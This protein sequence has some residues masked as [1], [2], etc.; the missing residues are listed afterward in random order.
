MSVNGGGTDED[1]AGTDF[2]GL[3]HE[4][5]M[6]WQRTTRKNGMEWKDVTLD[7]HGS[8]LVTVTWK[9]CLLLLGSLIVLPASSCQSLLLHTQVH[10]DHRWPRQPFPSRVWLTHVS[11]CPF[12]V[13][14]FVPY[15]RI[16]SIVF[17]K[18]VSENEYLRV[19][20]YRVS[21]TVGNVE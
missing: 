9:I 1:D 6:M 19:C 12:T 4:D 18:F 11:L 5:S 2:H 13:S 16:K 7:S 17:E 3:F 20:V 14:L 21:K 10:L 8:G 15:F